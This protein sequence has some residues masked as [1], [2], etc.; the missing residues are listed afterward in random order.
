MI[1]LE[2]PDEQEE[3]AVILTRAIQD[4]DGILEALEHLRL[5]ITK[6]SSAI[7]TKEEEK[8]FSPSLSSLLD[9]GPSHLRKVYSEIFD[10]LGR[11][12]NLLF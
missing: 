11:I 12:N 8:R 5:K 10:E 1:N 9:N 2:P 7:C 3:K 4:I 6:E